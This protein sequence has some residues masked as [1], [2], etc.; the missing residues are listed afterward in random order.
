MSISIMV[1]KGQ[2]GMRK[3][4]KKIKEPY[5][6]KLESGDEKHRKHGGEQEERK[7]DDKKCDVRREKKTRH[8][9]ENKTEQNMRK[10]QQ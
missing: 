1:E 9:N 8:E 7:K 10:G 2:S 6:W 5:N 4:P 3:K